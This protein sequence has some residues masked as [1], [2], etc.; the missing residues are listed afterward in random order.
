MAAERTQRAG[1]A[2]AGGGDA[3]FAGAALVCRRG[4]RLVLSGLSFR[5]RAGAALLLTGPNGAGKSSLLRLMAGLLAPAGGQLTWN[6]TAIAADPEAHRGRLAFLG[7]RDAVKPGL[8]VAE[9]LAVWAA[10]RGAPAAAVERALEAFGLEALA[11]LPARYLS[12]G[13]RR[14]LALARLLLVPRALWL[15]DEPQAGLDSAAIAALEAQIKTHLANG[16]LAVIATHG[17]LDL[18]GAALLDLAAG[19]TP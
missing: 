14:R 2:A 12:A 4:E 1:D 7:H 13:Q 16:G 9:N 11:E 5:L 19:A 18:P 3:E 15:L 6:G 8:G 10:L 17:G